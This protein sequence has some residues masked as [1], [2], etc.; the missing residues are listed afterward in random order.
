MKKIML[1]ALIALMMVGCD[2]NPEGTTR[3][4]DVY[5]S[6]TV[7]SCEYIICKGRLRGHKGNCKYCKERQQKKL[8]ELVKQLK[9]K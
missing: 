4:D 2:L 3:I 7:D 8:E 5:Y 1:L 9:E 6:I